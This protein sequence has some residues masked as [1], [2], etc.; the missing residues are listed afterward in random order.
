MY[1]K[2]IGRKSR[3][4]FY[5]SLLLAIA[6]NAVLAQSASIG[7][8]FNEIRVQLIPLRETILSSEVGGRID[9]V[10]VREGESFTEGQTLVRLDCTMHEIR[11]EKAEAL[12]LEAK[13]VEQVSARLDQLGSISTLEYSSAI[14][15]LA[16]ATAEVDLM[17]GIVERCDI[18]APFPG[19]IVELL[20]RSHQ[21]VAEGQELLEILDDSVM[22]V[23]MNVPS[24]WLERNISGHTV[25][26]RIE[27]TGKVYPAII[28]RIGARIDAVSQSVKLSGSVVGTYPEL[29]SGMSGTVVFD[30]Q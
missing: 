15:R 25:T 3:T 7:Q 23:E 30:D 5:C 20:A 8:S 14:A 17:R 11:L 1:I 10:V 22:L 18:K 27:E 9:E 21:F 4:S 12:L 16:A 26:L 13:S 24:Q 19:K 2:P 29:R 6:S 28:E